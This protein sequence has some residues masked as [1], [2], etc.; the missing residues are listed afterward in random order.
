MCSVS[1]EDADR[2]RCA[3]R[4]G[5]AG[6]I[7]PA[8][9]FLDQAPARYRS[10][11]RTTSRANGRPFRRG[12]RAASAS[13]AP[14]RTFCRAVSSQWG[15]RP[16]VRSN[17][18]PSRVSNSPRATPW[19]PFVARHIAAALI[20]AAASSGVGIVRYARAKRPYDAARRRRA[21]DRRGS[22]CSPAHVQPW[23]VFSTLWGA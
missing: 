20:Q 18:F 11:A 7:F 8:N 5:P 9:T 23:G 1:G 13:R 17:F 6:G 2:N 19:C 4:S 3:S 10:I 12:K 16:M 14:S 22:P 21:A 15:P